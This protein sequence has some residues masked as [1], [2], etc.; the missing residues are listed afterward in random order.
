MCDNDSC[1]ALRVRLVWKRRRRRQQNAATELDKAF[2]TRCYYIR[3]GLASWG[4]IANATGY[5]YEIDSIVGTTT[6]TRVQ[7]Q[8]NQTIIVKAVGG[9]KYE[10]SDPSALQNTR[11]SKRAA[12]KTSIQTVIATNAARLR[13]RNANMP[14]RMTTKCAMFAAEA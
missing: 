10:D 1:H 5:E 7:L 6:K 14:T 9:G 2:H 12:T 11:L 3:K 4:A 8:A 13:R